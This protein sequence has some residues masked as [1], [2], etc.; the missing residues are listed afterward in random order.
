[1][2]AKFI[3]RFHEKE[4]KKDNKASSKSGQKRITTSSN[5]RKQRP[6]TM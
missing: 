1:M 6:Q 3:E 2:C 4:L 5:S